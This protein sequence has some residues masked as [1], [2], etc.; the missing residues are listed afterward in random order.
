[1]SRHSSDDFERIVYWGQVG[2]A[3]SFRGDFESALETLGIIRYWADKAECRLKYEQNCKE[4][5]ENLNL[6]EK[7]K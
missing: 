7:D 2:Q 3:E 1:M 5:L 6:N 4:T